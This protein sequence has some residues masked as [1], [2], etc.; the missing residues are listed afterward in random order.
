MSGFSA[1]LRLQC[2]PSL[3]ASADR[4]GSHGCA[5]LRAG[6]PIHSG[7]LPARA[8]CSVVKTA[9]KEGP[10]RR[11]AGRW[12]MS[13]RRRRPSGSARRRPQTACHVILGPS[14]LRAN[15]HRCVSRPRRLGDGIRP[16]PADGSGQAASVPTGT[17]RHG[18]RPRAPEF[19]HI[20]DPVT[21]R[22]RGIGGNDGSAGNAPPAV[23]DTG[24]FVGGIR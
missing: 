18:Q 20:P 17:Q 2:R 5:A 8:V 4:I 7:T 14:F 21:I 11:A 6:P 15:I 24:R 3:A 22:H 1:E 19:D 16:G 10:R 23:L 13:P 9:G 12:A